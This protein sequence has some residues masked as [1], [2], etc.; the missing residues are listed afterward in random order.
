MTKL[1]EL[2]LFLIL[3]L[4][5]ILFCLLTP[6]GRIVWSILWGIVLGV[7]KIFLVCF[8]AL[9][10]G[11]V[12]FCGTAL[13]QLLFNKSLSCAV[14]I[15]NCSNNLVKIPASN[16]IKSSSDVIN[17]E[18]LVQKNINLSKLN[19]LIYKKEKLGKCIIDCAGCII[20]GIISFVAS[21]FY[22]NNMFFIRVS[23]VIIT[24]LNILL[25]LFAFFIWEKNMK[26]ALKNKTQLRC[27]E[28][29]Y[30][31]CSKLQILYKSKNIM[32][33]IRSFITPDIYDDF[34]TLDDIMYYKE[35]N[36][37]DVK[38]EYVFKKTKIYFYPTLLRYG[39]FDIEFE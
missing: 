26:I 7:T 10:M 36:K 24:L 33:K 38:V 35:K 29:I 2:L 4:A 14:K 37:I 20:L 23:I 19:K 34:V 21:N 25:C 32:N 15:R 31:N 18:I 22:F 16:F 1:K 9:G 39:V 3:L 6:I 11:V 12:L 28:D 27:C 8:F 17:S 5:T 30:Y 13:A